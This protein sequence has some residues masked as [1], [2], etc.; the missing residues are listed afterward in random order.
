MR[1]RRGANAIE[2]ALTFP[3][4][5]FLLFGLIEY[6]WYFY[7]RY[8]L[9]EVTRAGCRAG[10]LLHP[11]DADPSHR[12]DVTARIEIRKYCQHAGL[13]CDKGDG[14]RVDYVGASPDEALRCLTTQP[15]VRLTGLSIP[16]PRDMAAVAELHLELQR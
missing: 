1:T 8:Q 6:G 7:E 11:D 5:T 12:A 10:A 16:I 9:A 2:F 3:V 15:H 13:S 14:V 4:F